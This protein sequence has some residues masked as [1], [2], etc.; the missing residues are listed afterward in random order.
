[1]FGGTGSNRYD[2]L[3]NAPVVINGGSGSD[4]LVIEGTPMG[5][6]FV[7]TNTF[8]VG[9]GRYVTYSNIE[10]VEI[11]AGGGPDQI[12]VLGTRAGT[13][14]TIDGGS[15]DDVIHIGGCPPP[16]LVDADLIVNP[17]AVED[18][19]KIQGRLVLKGGTPS[20]TGETRSSSTTRQGPPARRLHEP[21][22]PADGPSRGGLEREPHLRSGVR[23]HRPARERLRDRSK[24]SGFMAGR[25]GGLGWEPLFRPRDHG[26]RENR[27]APPQ[28]G[29]EHV[30][31]G[32]G[33][34]PTFKNGADVVTIGA[35]LTAAITIVGGAGKDTVDIGRREEPPRS[36]AGRVTIRSTLKRGRA[37]IHRF[38]NPVLQR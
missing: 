29:R 8:I 26:R 7:V 18:L 9:A 28:P 27:G 21:S 30:H 20:R 24:V 3:A 10:N 36:S 16:V 6:L 17:P 22:H 1:V 35:P 23:R 2:Y 19:S 32:G 31:R 5:D 13:T 38:A 4:T 25:G 37:Q 12:Y 11:D 14:T 15:G 33:R 34:I